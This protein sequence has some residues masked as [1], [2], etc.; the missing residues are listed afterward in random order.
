MKKIILSMLVCGALFSAS[1]QTTT[2]SSTTTTT[3]SHKYYYYP[4]SNVYFDQTSGNYWYWDD[5]SSQWSSA[6]NLP[7]TITV[8]QTDRHPISYRG[9]DPWKNNATDK[10]KYKTKKN[11]KGKMKNK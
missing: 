6:Q 9:D 2:T 4:S 7:S 8:V 1:A 10:Q 3:T 11:G 5:A